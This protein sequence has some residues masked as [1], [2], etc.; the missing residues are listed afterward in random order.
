MALKALNFHN[1][2][3]FQVS[4]QLLEGG[5][6]WDTIVLRLREMTNDPGKI[7]ALIDMAGKKSATH[8]VKRGR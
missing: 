8:R 6:N 7:F 5:F 1:D 3:N 4:V 2:I